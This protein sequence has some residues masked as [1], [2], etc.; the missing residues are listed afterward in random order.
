MLVQMD[1][2][3]IDKPVQSVVITGEEQL[4]SYI[5]HVQHWAENELT[6]YITEISL[7]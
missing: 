7:N 5:R 4:L 1:S 6:S 3:T 2:F